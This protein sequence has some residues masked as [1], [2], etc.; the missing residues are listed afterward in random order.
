MT[1]KYFLGVILDY[2]L[3]LLRLVLEE[4]QF[5]KAII[6]VGINDIK[7]NTSRVQGLLQKKLK[8]AARFKAYGERKII[9]FQVLFVHVNL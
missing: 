3:Y 7:K 8:V 6:H 9:L 1:I 5:Y 2:P 4:S